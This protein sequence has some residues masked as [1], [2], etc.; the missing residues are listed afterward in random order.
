[1]TDSLHNTIRVS[2]I[3]TTPP[4][5]YK[6]CLQAKT[7]RLLERL[8]VSYR[9]VDTD[10][11]VTM[12]DCLAIDRALD[13]KIVK[14]LFLCNRNKSSYVLF[15]TP[16]DKPFRTSIVSKAL[17]VS[18]LSFA[19]AEDLHSLLGIEIGDTSVFCL[20]HDA[21]AKVRLALDRAILTTTDY[22]CT[23]GTNTGY[24]TLA[25]RDLLEKVLPEIGRVPEIIDV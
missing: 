18:R 5:T 9:R 8:A 25:T 22:G 23:D 1:M 2:R 19:S 6:S 20:L 7:Y 15:V 4:V 13:T 12:D 14:T 24:L 11:A 16:G 17:G 3:F 21:A 10:V